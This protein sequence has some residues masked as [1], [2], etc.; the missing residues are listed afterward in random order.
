VAALRDDYRDGHMLRVTFWIVAVFLAV[1]LVVFLSILAS[2]L[3]FGHE[4][5]P[6]DCCSDQHCHPVPCNEL[7]YFIG[8]YTWHHMVF[9]DIRESPDGAC[10]VCHMGATPMCVMPGGMS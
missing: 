7:T 10:H 3:I 6:K 2:G 1:F 5:Y 4:Q 9:K 8:G